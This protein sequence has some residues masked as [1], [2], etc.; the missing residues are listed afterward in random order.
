M[1]MEILQVAREHLP[2][3]AALEKICFS[4]PWSENALGLFSGDGAVAF[5]AVD[6][7]KI[8]GYIGMLLAPDE[9]Q[10][11]NLAVLPEARRQGVANAL[12]ARLIREAETRG[13]AALSLEVRVSNSPAVRLYESF[14][15]QTA[16]E[17]KG[18][19]RHPVEN[20][21]VMIRPIAPKSDD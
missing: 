13:L 18:F 9:G 6:K 19:Y 3:I 11:L 14:G 1:K 7:E 21:L 4:E 2:G 12:V 8:L 10:I 20:A 5:A 17:R 15:F 16:G